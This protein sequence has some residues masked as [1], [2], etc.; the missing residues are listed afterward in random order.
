MQHQS[1]SLGIRLHRFQ[2]HRLKEV[3]S[4]ENRSQVFLQEVTPPGETKKIGQVPSFHRLFLELES[5]PDWLSFSDEAYSA[6]QWKVLDWVCWVD[7][8][9]KL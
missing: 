7:W 9:W 8:Q 1:V 3:F 2:F 4:S 6:V 5:E